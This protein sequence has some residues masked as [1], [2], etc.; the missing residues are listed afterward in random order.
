MWQRSGVGVSSRVLS[1][2]SAVFARQARGDRRAVVA[3][4]HEHGGQIVTEMM[5]VGRRGAVGLGSMA[6]EAQRQPVVN[7]QENAG[8]ID[9]FPADRLM[10]RVDQ[11]RLQNARVATEAPQLLGEGGRPHVGRGPG[12]RRK[13]NRFSRTP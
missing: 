6:A 13:S 11:S 10:H 5:V 7:R 3:A 8:A 1:T 2:P 12:A 9:R 4:H